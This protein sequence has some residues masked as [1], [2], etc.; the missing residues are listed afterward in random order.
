MKGTI[1]SPGARARTAAVKDLSH[2]CG[3]M[4]FDDAVSGSNQ[5]PCHFPAGCPP[6]EA[7][8]ASEFV[9]YRAG[10]HRTQPHWRDG[11]SHYSRAPLRP[12][13][14]TCCHRGLSTYLTVDS[15]RAA[16][17]KQP[18]RFKSVLRVCA[19]RTRGVATPTP[20]GGDD[21]H[22]LWLSAEHEESFASWC[23]V[24][25]SIGGP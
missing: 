12:E 11:Q 17:R 23:S 5:W 15:V 7:Q 20:R 25:G 1:A 24:V 13:F 6:S 14:D 16:M 19:P 9:L 4:C 22:T 21:H 8:D 10:K 18:R 2:E 3:S